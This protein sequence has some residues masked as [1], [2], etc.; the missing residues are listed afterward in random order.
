M[1]LCHLSK[2]AGIGGEIKE[3][4][5]DFVVEEISA[6]PE[7]LPSGDFAYFWLV[8]KGKTTQE[9]MAAIAN[10]LGTDAAAFSAAGQKD[11]QACTRQ[12]ASGFG[13]TEKMLASLS[14]PP[15]IKVEFAGYLDEKLKIGQLIGNRFRI[16]VGNPKEKKPGKKVAAIFGDLGKAFPNYFGAQRFGIRNNTH[17]VGK[18][19]VQGRTQDAAEEFLSG[20]GEGG[21]GGAEGVRGR[22]GGNWAGGAESGEG[23]EKTDARARLKNEGDYPA[24]LQYFPNSLAYERMMLGVLS[25]NSNDFV[26][27]FLSLPRPMLLLFVHAYQAHLFNSHLSARVKAGEI[28]PEN[29]LGNEKIFNTNP[30][31]GFPDENSNSGRQWLAINLLGQESKLNEY[32]KEM[33]EGEEV[34]LS[35]FK[36]RQMPMLGAKG[37]MRAALAPLANFSFDGEWFSFSLPSGSYATAALREFLDVGKN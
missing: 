35:D 13:I 11:R 6:M 32:E 15:G 21:A 20:L 24:A 2:L 12:L 16:K 33:L 27:A 31:T 28:S 4:P 30:N 18:L 3:T 29:A 17:I 25:K 36:I 23:K 9:A 34:R 5:D 10:A 22:K 1:T 19:L 37:G 7:F 8:K 14:L 26:R